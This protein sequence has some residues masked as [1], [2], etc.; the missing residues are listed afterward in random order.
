MVLIEVLPLHPET[1]RGAEISAEII[2][3]EPDTDNSDEGR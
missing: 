3:I 1:S 2:P